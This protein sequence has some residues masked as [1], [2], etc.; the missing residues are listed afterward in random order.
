MPAAYELI[1]SGQQQR[2][3]RPLPG[4]ILIPPTLLVVADSEE[5]VSGPK[6]TFQNTP[7][8]THLPL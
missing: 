7:Y 2:W 4:A 6:A 5:Q 8:F 1:I 3:P